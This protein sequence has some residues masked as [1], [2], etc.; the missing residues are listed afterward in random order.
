MK[1]DDKVKVSYMGNLYEGVVYSIYNGGLTVNVKFKMNGKYVITAFPKFSVM[2]NYENELLK[3]DA[4]RI[5]TLNIAF[6]DLRAGTKLIE[7]ANIS[8]SKTVKTLNG[9]FYSI[10][11]RHFDCDDC[12]CENEENNKGLNNSLELDN[13]ESIEES[14]KNVLDI[15][16]Y[17]NT[18]LL[19]N[20]IDKE[21]YSEDEEEDN[22]VISEAVV[23]NSIEYTCSLNGQLGFF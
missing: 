2:S 3:Y 9:A 21:M 15:K 19:H 12:I 7:I 22:D 4:S 8:S 23:E 11:L 1:K 6:R 16:E 14:K 20:S 17:V 10:P 5:V 18:A 13:I